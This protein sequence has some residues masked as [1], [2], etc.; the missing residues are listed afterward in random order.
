MMYEDKRIRRVLLFMPGDSLRKIAKGAS[1]GVD[2]I[3]MDLEDGVASNNKAEA[4]ETVLYAL[5]SAGIDFGNTERLVRVNDPSS[6]FQEQDVAVTIKGKPD[7]Y[8]LPKVESAREVQEFCHLLM[9]H[10]LKLGYPLGEIKVLTVIETARGVVA[11]R[12]IA[13]SDQ[14]L[15]AL[16]FG[17]E[18]LAGDIGAVRSPMGMEVFYARS[19]LIIHAAAYGLQAIDTPFVDLHDTEG[20]RQQ[21][22]DAVQM[23]YTGKLAIHPKQ[24]GPILDEFTPS[25]EELAA[26]EQLIAAH[27]EYQANGT[28]VFVYEGRMVDMPMIRAARRVVARAS[29]SNE[30]VQKKTS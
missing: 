18:D 25:A 2:S 29:S 30:K 9:E 23:G 4:R 6:G 15:V 24:I 11:M 17:A 28:G 27:E 19:K 10:E 26:A 14:R 20:L 22:R 13:Q 12:E 1:L 16:V 5:T 7:G 8:V 3:I 21:T